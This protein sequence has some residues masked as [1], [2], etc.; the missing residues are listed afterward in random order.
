M[1]TQIKPLQTNSVFSEVEPPLKSSIQ[2]SQLNSNYFKTQNFKNHL[3]M[4][5]II[6]AGTIAL[7]IFAARSLQ[8][9]MENSIIGIRSFEIKNN[10]KELNILTNLFGIDSK[11][12][13]DQKVSLFSNP[14]SEKNDKD[15]S[16]QLKDNKLHEVSKEVHQLFQSQPSSNINQKQTD[17]KKEKNSSS[18]ALNQALKLKPQVLDK[19]N[20]VQIPINETPSHSMTFVDTITKVI[21]YLPNVAYWLLVPV[22]LAIFHENFSEKKILNNFLK[23]TPINPV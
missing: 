3:A 19:K 5:L 2:H 1:N 14:I 18:P 6:T 17:V 4:G 20:F 16:S 22:S 13:R 10:S 21:S 8:S 12:D 11:S 9:Q 23:P 15:E 7:G